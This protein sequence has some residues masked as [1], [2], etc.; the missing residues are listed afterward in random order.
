M[1]L[2]WTGTLSLARG[3]TAAA[4]V[5]DL[6]GIV[7]STA[8]ALAILASTAT[9]GKMLRSG[10]SAAPAW[11]TPTFPNTATSGKV[12]QGDGTNIVLS[13]FTFPTAVGA[14]RTFLQS[15][16]TNY[17]ASAYTF[18]T[19]VGA[20]GTILRSDATNWVATT[21]T[22]PDTVVTNNVLGATATN[23]IGA[24]SNGVMSG[25][26]NSNIG[27]QCSNTST[28]TAGFA[29]IRALNS[30]ATGANMASFS[31]GLTAAGSVFG[32]L[33]VASD[34]MFYH[35]NAVGKMNIGTTTA[36]DVVLFSGGTALANERMRI[37]STGNVAITGS[38]TTVL[39][40]PTAYLH[41]GAGL[42]AAS[43]AP[44]KFTSGTNNTTPENGAQEYN[45]TN[46]FFTR[47]GAVREYVL[48][49]LDAA[50]APGT[51]NIGV[52]LD[53]YGTSATRVLT[54]PNSWISIVIGATTYKIPAYT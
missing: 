39:T 32:T 42:A 46:L 20:V 35:N 33:I 6:G 38:G 37:L 25:S 9:A 13:A 8:S 53:Y 3:G 44:L 50:A 16:G 40:A 12:L 14:I 18:P 43:S 48:T 19:A 27:L 15:D 4:L 22:Y 52:I 2:G 30:T 24:I 1:T 21:A 34:T 28:S 7:Y 11:S 17:V 49:G 45:G 54:T 51:A 31:S 26:P 5:A 47:A 10:A 23:V 41:L 36:K 29:L